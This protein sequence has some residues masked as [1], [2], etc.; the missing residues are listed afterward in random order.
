MKTSFVSNLAVQNAMRLTIQQGQAELLKLQTEV[1]T[2]R[3]ADVGLALGSSA[4]R[5]VSLQR[6]LARLG[7]LVDTNSVVTQ[8]L[9]ASQSALSAMAEAAQQ[10]RNTLVTFKG[11]DAADQLA[12]QK[13]EIQS[14]M[15]AFS[16]AANLSFNGEF[17]FAGINTDVR[18]LEDY[19]AAAKST[20]DTALATYMSANGI[21]SMSDFTKAQMEDFITNTL[22]PLYDTE[23]AADWSKASSQNMTSRISTTEVV[24]SST[25]ATTE[26]FRKFALASVIALELMD[27]NVSSEVRAYIGEAALGYV[28]QANTQITAERS[29]LGI[30]EARVKKA[31]TSLQ[32]Q[33]KLINT[34]ITDL[35]GVD[36]YEAST[37]MNTLLT[38]VETSYT[39]TARIQRLSLIDFL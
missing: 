3:H 13:T 38:Q 7:T 36:T 1:T 24:Q 21:T 35:E 26:G 34:H 17:L 15:S 27:E 4:A 33:I 5:S 16:S 12:I 28:E 29:T 39:L 6:E 18:P 9:A 37:R 11:N 2:G 19:N 31:N 23:W 20:F 30:S 32:A 8:R 25:N 10:V 22:E 14:A